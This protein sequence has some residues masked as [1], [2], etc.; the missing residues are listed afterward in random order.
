MKFLS[1]MLNK[2]R[3]EPQ[4]PATYGTVQAAEKPQRAPLLPP[5]QKKQQMA[6][7]QSGYNEMLDLSRSIR[8]H[9]ES[10]QELQVKIGETLDQVPEAVGHLRHICRN[11]DRQTEA[12]S[13]LVDSTGKT[14]EM[15]HDVM[16]RSE[17]RLVL[18]LTLFLLT[19]IAVI[20]GGIYLVLP[21]YQQQPQQIAVVEKVE[22]KTPE[23]AEE[24]EIVDVPTEREQ[25]EK[26]RRFLFF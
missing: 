26:K 16:R 24:P 1:S 5:S 17:R 23:V 8:D 20:G 13:S 6:A 21:Q 4:E 2:L 11:A 3:G 18:T 9:L 7:L 19:I 14:Q 12:I 22:A 10:Q 25:P 15:L